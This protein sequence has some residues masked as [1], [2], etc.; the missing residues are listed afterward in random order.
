MAMMNERNN[1]STHTQHR[2]TAARLKKH[3]ELTAKYE[4][5]GLTRDAASKKA[6]DVVT[7][8]VAS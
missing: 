7:G 2:D 8:K 3:A 6:F 1:R 4:A 5:E